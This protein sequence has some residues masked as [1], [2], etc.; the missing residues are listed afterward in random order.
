MADTFLAGNGIYTALAANSTLITALGGTAIYENIAPQG[1]NLPYV[2]FG[3]A[4]GGDEN[5]TPSEM[6]N[7]L[8]DVKAVASTLATAKTIAALIHST[9]HGATLTVSGWTNFLTRGEGAIRFAEMDGSGN[10]VRH[11]GKTYRVRLGQ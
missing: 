3:W 6:V 10:Q 5:L 7:E 2:I 4:G 1:T 8:W 9:L 11:L